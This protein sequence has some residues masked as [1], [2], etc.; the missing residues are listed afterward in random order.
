MSNGQGYQGEARERSEAYGYSGQQAMRACGQLW[1]KE[2]H[3]SFAQQGH[4]RLRRQ[5]IYS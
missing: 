1:A 3:V 2:R 4:E 5:G